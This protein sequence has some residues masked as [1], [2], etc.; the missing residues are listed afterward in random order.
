MLPEE[1]TFWIGVGV[2]AIVAVAL[3]KVLAGKLGDKFPALADLAAF[4]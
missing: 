3:F 1:V 2:V 4:I